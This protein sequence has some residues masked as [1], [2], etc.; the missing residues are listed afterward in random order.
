MGTVAVA[1]F[2]VRRAIDA[3]PLLSL[4][5]A[6]ATVAG[7]L[8]YMLITGSAALVLCAVLAAY[9]HL[10]M[11]MPD[12]LGITAI[13][14]VTVA[15]VIANAGVRH[16]KQEITELAAIAEVT[17]RVLLRPV[18]RQVGPVRIA[19]RY[20]SAS[21]GARI[22]G[23]LYDTVTTYAGLRFIIGDV[24][25]KGLPAVQTAATVLGAFR[26]SAYD[27]PGL[28]V[29]ADRIEA[30]LARQATSEQFVTALLAQ[31][32]DD[33]SKIDLLN[34]GHPPPLLLSMGAVRF[35]DPAEAALPLGLAELAQ[36]SGEPATTAFGPGDCML[37]YT[38]G[39]SEARSE[40]GEYFSVSRSLA[41]A[42]GAGPGAVRAGAASAG[43][44]GPGPARG[45]PGPGAAAAPGA[46]LARLSDDV[47]RHVGHPLDDDAAMLLICRL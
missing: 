22:G 32:S 9:H 4:G 20:T 28:T 5:P 12:I 24:Q 23:D 45:P 40:S 42:V 44:A 39:I 41:R 17:Q 6:F 31:V 1:V 30:S 18:P 27:A 10:I 26:E 35:V 46:I 3:L 2:L 33:G 7:E 47:L 36:L 37:F 29:I 15:G 14:G 19:V 21:R 8:L 11:S 13:A 34:R 43:V 16:R 25:G 38:D